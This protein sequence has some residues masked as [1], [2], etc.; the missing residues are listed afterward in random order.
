L[1]NPHQKFVAINIGHQ[2]Q[3]CQTPTG[4]VRILGFYEHAEEIVSHY[5]GK[6]DLDVFTVPVGSWFAI[7]KKPTEPGEEENL[8]NSVVERVNT[9][10]KK[11]KDE[12][13][14]V[15][16]M[17][18]T[19]KEEDRY[20]DSVR[21]LERMQNVDT[22]MENNKNTTANI[23]SKAPPVD[24]N[25]EIRGQNY[26]VISIITE[27]SPNDEPLVQFFQGFD[28]RDDARDYMRNTL[29]QTHIKTNCFVV[30]MYEWV[31]PFYTK[32]FKFKETVEASFTH[33]ELE[34]LFQGQKWENQ[35]IA[36]MMES[37][38]A[39]NRLAEIEEEFDNERKGSDED[40]EDTKQ[41]VEPEEVD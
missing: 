29:H 32:S 11:V 1:I 7:T 12:T 41:V 31:V 8:K 23:E 2:N 26:A 21:S 17:S 14:N 34:E 9:F 28:S 38:A 30:Q 36:Q 15:V 13:V 10:I 39:K 5:N 24:R 6:T 22:F 4:A 35:K 25:Q 3:K 37:E 16:E 19:A 18:E 33:S 40:E 27:A 20:N